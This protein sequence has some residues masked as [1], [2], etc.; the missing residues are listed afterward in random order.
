MRYLIGEDTHLVGLFESGKTIT[1]QIL[2]LDTNALFEL[3]TNQC[4]ESSIPGVYIFPTS[5]IINK[6]DSY[7]N[8]FYK[9]EDDTGNYFVGKFVLGG[10]PDYIDTILKIEKGGRII[11]NNEMA[12]FD[13]KTDTGTEVVRFKLYDKN[14]NPTETNVFRREPV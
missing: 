1:I 4:I 8:C 10:Y 13:G 9:M 12:Y 6:P 3:T 14:G 2:N 5:N 11:E 7:T